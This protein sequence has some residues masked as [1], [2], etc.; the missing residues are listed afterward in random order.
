MRPHYIFTPE[1]GCDLF[2][3]RVRFGRRP[4]WVREVR[5]ETVRAFDAAEPGPG[6]LELD[7]ADE[8]DLTF[9][10][11]QRYLGYGAQWQL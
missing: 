4:E 1:L 3:L 5:G 9:P 6:K 7:K 2:R 10:E 8:V 11:P